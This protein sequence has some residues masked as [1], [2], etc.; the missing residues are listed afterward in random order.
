MLEINGLT[1]IYGGS[2]NKAIDDVSFTVNN[3]EVVGFA[4]LNGAGKTT[5]LRIM[6]GSILP[7]EGTVRVDQFDIVK[8]KPDASGQVGYVPESNIYD[9]NSKPLSLMRYFSGFS[10]NQQFTTDSYLVDLLDQV[11][12]KPFI[13]KKLRIYSNGMKKRFSIAASMIGD[14]PNYLFD[15]TL[16]N[17]D[18]EGVRFVRNFILGLKKQG[19]AILLSS[20]ILG[21][22]GFIADRVIILHKGKLVSTLDGSKLH[23]S[24]KNNVQVTIENPDQRAIDLLSRFGEVTL[25]K[26]VITVGNVSEKREIIN[27]ISST[28]I[29][30]GYV[31][32]S[33]NR[34][35]S[36]LE[37]FFFEIIGE[38]K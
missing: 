34:V 25:D 5:A 10:E 37:N 35:A 32:S 18:P 6:A 20:H 15:E 16:S 19:K 21:E 3:G 8:D 30:S 22:L 38:N 7:T 27:E 12:I 23:S 28:L 33:I 4:G 29:S 1:K 36:S 31:I 24:I 26:E 17:L 2:K 9:L 11:G 13:G 14:P